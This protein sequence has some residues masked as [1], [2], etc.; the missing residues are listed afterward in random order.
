MMKSRE[1][2]RQVERKGGKKQEM[3][4]I[5]VEITDRTETAGEI[6]K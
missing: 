3:I 4:K 6:E 1:E 5:E 2:D